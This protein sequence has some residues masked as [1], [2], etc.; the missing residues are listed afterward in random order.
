MIARLLLLPLQLLALVAGWCF[1]SWV[2]R[3]FLR[4]LEADA[5]EEAGRRER[6]RLRGLTFRVGG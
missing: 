6:H 4:A 1:G 5:L 3:R 2:A